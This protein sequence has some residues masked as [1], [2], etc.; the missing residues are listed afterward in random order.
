MSIHTSTMS[1]F[2]TPARQEQPRQLQSI[3]VGDTERMVS[4]L[5]GGALALTGLTRGSLSGLGLA[6][7]GGA[8]AY[9]GMTGHCSLYGA[10]GMSTAEPRGMATGVRAQRGY[11][12]ERTLLINR[13]ADELYRF[14]RN[15]ENL[16]RIMHHLE[17][18]T[19]TSDRSSHWKAK[20][21]LG[22]SV[23]WDA[24]IHN[25]RE[26][27]MI[28]WR[29]IEGSQVDTAGSIHFEPALGGRGTIMRVS[30]KYDP[31]LGKVGATIAS[32]LGEGLEHQLDNDLRDFKQLMEAGEIASAGS[33]SGTTSM[34]GSGLSSGSAMNA[35][36]S[37]SAMGS[38]TSG[39]SC[40]MP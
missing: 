25:E 21:P 29:S 16:P 40:P 14:W 33:A 12:L 35:P 31:P 36:S 3:N 8:L 1:Q 7:L 5:A 10:L 2:H 28:A 32:I 6:A 38:S 22:T 23:E 11:K 9:R 34:S 19:M 18:V 4:L 27:E 39:S 26:G 15:L 13:P 24:E 30:M 20:G 17:S 37:Q